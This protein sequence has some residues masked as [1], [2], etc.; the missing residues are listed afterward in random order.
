MIKT[1]ATGNPQWFNVNSPGAYSPYGNMSNGVDGQLR[2]NT[3]TQQYEA[4]VSGTWQTIGGIASVDPSQRMI[5]I[6]QWAES[7]MHME[8]EV[9][10]LV[11]ENLTVADSYNNYKQAE[12][13]LKMVMTLV[14]DN[15]VA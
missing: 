9:M 4:F 12:S 11:E 2:L 13:Q 6:L 10:K 8:R 7:K 1:V 3:S 15:S 5:E 14:K